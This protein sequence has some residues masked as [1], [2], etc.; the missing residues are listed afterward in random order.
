MPSE[1]FIFNEVEKTEETV[2]AGQVTV[3]EDVVA[4]VAIDTLSKLENVKPSTSGFMSDLYHGKKTSSGVRVFCEE[5]ARRVIRIDVF[6][7]VKYGL[8]IPDVC[9]DVQEQVKTRV[10]EV[11]GL[12]VDSVNI[13]VQGIYFEEETKTETTIPEK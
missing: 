9:W 4:S 6:V 7:L 8:R 11:T 10:E 5:D 13:Y 1:E 2:E 12:V 3:S